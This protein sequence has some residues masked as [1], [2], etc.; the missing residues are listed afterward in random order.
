MNEINSFVKVHYYLLFFK[1]FSYLHSW[2][3]IHTHV[4]AMYLYSSTSN[5]LILVIVLIKTSSELDL[6]TK[7]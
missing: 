7:L 6:K 2:Q 3:F 4:L 1:V 5:I